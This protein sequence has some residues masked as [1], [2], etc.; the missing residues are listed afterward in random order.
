MKRYTKAK[1][2][3]EGSTETPVFVRFST[4]IHGNHSPAEVDGFIESEQGIF[5]NLD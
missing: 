5:K 3:Q 4:V 1:L 2:F